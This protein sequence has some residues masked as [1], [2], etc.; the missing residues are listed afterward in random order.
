ME[1]LFYFYFYFFVW[2]PLSYPKM[3]IQIKIKS[4]QGGEQVCGERTYTRGHH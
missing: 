3:N 1:F 4:G 2:Q